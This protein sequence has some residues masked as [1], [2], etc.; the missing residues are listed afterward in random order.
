MHW[1]IEGTS[2]EGLGDAPA[3][4]GGASPI[5]FPAEGRGAAVVVAP[6]FAAP[7]RVVAATFGAADL[8]RPAAGVTV[9]PTHRRRV[10]GPQS[11]PPG[12]AR[13]ASRTSLGL[14]TPRAPVVVTG[15]GSRHGQEQGQT[16]GEERCGQGEP[17]A[18]GRR[19]R[20]DGVHARREGIEIALEGRDLRPGGGKA[21]EARAKAVPP[22]DELGAGSGLESQGPRFQGVASASKA[23]PDDGKV[24]S[25]GLHHLE[26]TARPRGC[27]SRLIPLEP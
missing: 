1:G 9:G 17:S 21:V 23:L 11:V 2:G 7:V 15:R 3:S 18:A 20:G 8:G 22:V 24:V 6:R 4:F 25:V 5:V 13:A 26:A 14:G 12:R 19:E 10:A 16:D 27:A